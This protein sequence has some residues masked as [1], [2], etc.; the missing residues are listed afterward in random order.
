MKRFLKKI[1][2]TTS[3]TY[4]KL[5]NLDRDIK[6]VRVEI[7]K[8]QVEIQKQANIGNKNKKE[9]IKKIK[10][11]ITH[12]QYSL[13]YELDDKQGVTDVKRNPMLIVSLTTIPSRIDQVHLVI[14]SIFMQSVKPDMVLLYLDDENFNINEIPYKLLK[15][16]EKGLT[17]CFCGNLY[18]YKKLIPA[19][20]KFPNE[21]IVT[22]DDDVLYPIDWLERLYSSYQIEPSSIHAHRA[23]Q[24]KFA[25]NGRLQQYSKWDIIKGDHPSSLKVFPTGVGGVLYFP[26]CFDDDILN[27]N[28]IIELCPTAD[29]IWFKAMSLK[30]GVKCKKASGDVWD[31]IIELNKSQEKA[32]WH[33]NLLNGQNDE[34]I[35]KV[36]DYYNLYSILNTNSEN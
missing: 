21:I 15:Q 23:R 3:P 4:R 26:G 7:Q 25:Q 29:D 2:F 11:E 35:K 31:R 10:T 16:Q 28:L 8:Q 34:Q 32:L 30:K 33:A 12:L 22:A 5:E 36:F 9:I 27:E 20:Q 13:L 24:M 18:A 6:N 1:L 17:I 14:E 19:L